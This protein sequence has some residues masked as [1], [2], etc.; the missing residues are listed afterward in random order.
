MKIFKDILKQ[1]TAATDKQKRAKF[2]VVDTLSSFW[3]NV[4]NNN[5]KAKIF[6]ASSLLASFSKASPAVNS[7]ARDVEYGNLSP[8]A[9]SIWVEVVDSELPAHLGVALSYS[10]K[11]EQSAE[12]AKQN[13]INS[14]FAWV[15]QA[16][17][18]I[19]KRYQQTLPLKWEWMEYID[20][21]GESVSSILQPADIPQYIDKALASELKSVEFIHHHLCAF[22]AN[23]GL[24]AVDLINRDQVSVTSHPGAQ[25]SYY[26]LENK[27]NVLQSGFNWTRCVD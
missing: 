22:I 12:W 27:T 3:Q 2:Q 25:Y 11:T 18:F 13:G 26:V 7:F 10:E 17:S 20:D 16:R 19:K 23:L 1:A 4:N 21:K 24:Y 6:D 5:M 8:F 15:C 14:P 9:Q